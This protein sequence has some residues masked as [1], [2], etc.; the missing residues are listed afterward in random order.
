[1]DGPIDVDVI[2]LQKGVFPGGRVQMKAEN[3]FGA[4]QMQLDSLLFERVQF[5]GLCKLVDNFAGV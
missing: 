1:M 2:K 4:S 5:A 3:A